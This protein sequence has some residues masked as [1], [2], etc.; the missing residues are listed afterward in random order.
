[1]MT[2]ILADKMRVRCS[3]GQVHEDVKMFVRDRKKVYIDC[4]GC[5]ID[6]VEEV[7][8][9]IVMVPPIMLAAAIQECK[10]CES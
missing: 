9:A 7:E 10:E 2:P 3:D 1:M 4:D 6:D 5:E 8:K